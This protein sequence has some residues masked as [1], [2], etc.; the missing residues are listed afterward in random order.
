MIASGGLGAIGYRLV[1]HSKP[2][3]VRMFELSGSLAREYVW[4]AFPSQPERTR[5]M[6]FPENDFADAMRIA[7]EARARASEQPFF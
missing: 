3:H 6:R 2:A 4:C 7:N 1:D 5:L